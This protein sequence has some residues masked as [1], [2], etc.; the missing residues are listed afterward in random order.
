MNITSES[1]LEDLLERYPAAGVV[2]SRYGLEA[3]EEADPSCKSVVRFA[4]DRGIPVERLLEELNRVIDISRQDPLPSSL[5]YLR[6]PPR[7]N[8]TRVRLPGRHRIRRGGAL[9]LASR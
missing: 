4:G 3:Y 8:P 6:V 5:A 1:L 9:G 7:V 2:L